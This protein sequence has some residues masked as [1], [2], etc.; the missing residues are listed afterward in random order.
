MAPL[1]QPSEASPALSLRATAIPRQCQSQPRSSEGEAAT[2]Y[3]QKLRW[4]SQPKAW[5]FIEVQPPAG[6]VA[7]AS[8]NLWPRPGSQCSSTPRACMASR[9]FLKAPGHLSNGTIATPAPCQAGVHPIVPRL[10]SPRSGAAGRGLGCRVE[11]FFI[12]LQTFPLH[13]SFLLQASTCLEASSP[14][15][16]A[17]STAKEMS[18]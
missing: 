2:A 4:L 17:F 9:H 7:W 11:L 1:L 12:K 15:P 3:L 14:Y 16:P 10:H 18:G 5:G 13:P 8:P 6:W